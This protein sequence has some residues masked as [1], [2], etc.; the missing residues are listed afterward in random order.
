MVNFPVIVTLARFLL[1]RFVAYLYGIELY[2]DHFIQISLR[3]F[4]DVLIPPITEGICTFFLEFL[5]VLAIVD[6]D[7]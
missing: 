5:F 6:P 4:L 3:R 1:R 2:G 7:S